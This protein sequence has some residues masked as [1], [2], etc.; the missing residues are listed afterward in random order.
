VIEDAYAEIKEGKAKV[1]PE[2]ADMLFR[3]FDALGASFNTIEK[4]D[5][6]AATL[7]GIAQELKNLTGVQTS[8]VGK[9]VRDSQQPNA[10]DAATPALAP[11]TQADNT[12]EAA[13]IAEQLKINTLPVHVDDLDTMMSLIEELVVDR[14]VLK[15]LVQEL[16]S[17]KLRNYYEKAGRTSDALQFQVMKIRA[18]PVKLVFDHFPRTVRDLARTLNKHIELVVEGQD[19]A[20]DRTIVERLDEPLTH[21]IRNAADHGLGADGGTIRLSARREQ[22][23]ALI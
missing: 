2:L 14:L 15:D 17:K 4:D 20:L 13:L 1:T 3:C 19:L 18:V 6:E 22:D 9:T 10:P 11:A 16:D 5:A 8:G 12:E 21:L 7:T 23:Y